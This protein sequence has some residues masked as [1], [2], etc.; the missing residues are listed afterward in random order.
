MRNS[1]VDVGH[2]FQ[3][4]SLYRR[5]I[6]PAGHVCPWSALGKA[7]KLL[8]T[9]FFELI[10][11][12]N[13]P[14]R[15]CTCVAD[16]P[17]EQILCSLSLVFRFGTYFTMFSKCNDTSCCKPSRSPFFQIYPNRFVNPP[18]AIDRSSNVIKLADP[19]VVTP[20]TRLIDPL[21]AR[22]MN[23]G[24]DDIPFDLHAPSARDHIAE[25]TCPVCRKYFSSHAQMVR[26]RI[27]LH[28]RTRQKLPADYEKSLCESKPDDVLLVYG[29]R[30][31]MFKVVTSNGITDVMDLPDSHPA[32]KE[33]KR[34]C[35]GD[36]ASFC[37]FE[38]WLEAFEWDKTD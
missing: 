1:S 32:V 25:R 8:P 9:M 35:E 31:D 6:L 2:S 38:A 12:E 19:A 27:S 18:V 20:K 3:L 16:Q 24:L 26:H 36:D 22:A 17:V 34:K 37:V 23:I 7:T 10:S 14:T 28:Y 15:R 4:L 13:A 5:V 29:R 11:S 21:Q 30:D 33:F